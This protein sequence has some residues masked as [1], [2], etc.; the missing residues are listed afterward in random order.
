MKDKKYKLITISDHV[1]APSGVG[2]Q[3]RYIVDKLVSTGKFQI[4]ALAG[5]IKHQDYTP[6]KTQEWGDDVII[7]PVDGYGNPAIIRQLLDIEKPDAIWFMTD[8]R[9]YEWLWAIEDEI[10]QVCPLIYNHLWDENPFPKYN[11]P[12]YKSTDY[13]VCINKLTYNMLKE[14]GISHCE[15]VPHGVPEKDFYPLEQNKIQELKTKHL[16]NELKDSFIGFYNS[17]NAL[18]KRTGNVMWAWKLF[19]DKL[20]EEERNNCVLALHTPPHDPEGQDLFKVAEMLDIRRHVAFNDK[21]VEPSVMNEFY[22]MADFTVCLSSEEGFGLSSLESLMVGTPV[23]STRTGGLQDQNI[24]PDTGQEFGHSIKADAVS[25]IGSQRTPYIESH[26]VDP[27]T[28][29]DKIM[30]LYKKKKELGAEL[31]KETVA[32]KVA[33]ESVLRRFN[34]PKIQ[35][36]W[37]EIIE[38]QIEIFKQKQT[39]D[40]L[41]NLIAI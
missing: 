28:A 14:N 26:H 25:L 24:D 8:P 31:Y 4:I 22:N 32:G 1:M 36:R 11:L 7:V 38:E 16:S 21:K 17:R 23:I 35:D 19:L 2:T 5:A 9:F 37:V 12:Y 34:L 3:T 29:A 20:P 39:E 41:V 10:H 30:D 13:I 15:Y 6:Q 27:K 33:R 18:R 40:K